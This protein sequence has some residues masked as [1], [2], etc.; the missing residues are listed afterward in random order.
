MLFISIVAF[1]Q[2]SKGYSNH[3]DAKQDIYNNG[4]PGGQHTVDAGRAGELHS[5]DNGT[6]VNNEYHNPH[7]YVKTRTTRWH[8]TTTYTHYHTTKYHKTRYT[9]HGIHHPNGMGK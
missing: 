6:H 7:P 8:H 4:Q 9:H 2:N 3:S 5:S 1:S